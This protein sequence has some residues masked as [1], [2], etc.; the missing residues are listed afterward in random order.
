M[1][2]VGFYISVSICIL[3]QVFSHLEGCVQI[4]N[5]RKVLS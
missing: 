3:E 2:I 1:F 4:L 5:K